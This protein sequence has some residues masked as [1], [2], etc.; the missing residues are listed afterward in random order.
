[1][2]KRIKY[3]SKKI[4]IL[5]NGCW[6]WTARRFSNGYG[7]FWDGARNRLAHRWS[8][9]H[10]VGS[11]PDDLCLDHLC[12]NRACVNPEHLEPVTLGEHLR[13]GDTITAR[14]AAQTHCIHGHALSGNNLIRRRNGTR[15][16]RECQ[17][18]NWRRTWAIRKQKE[19]ESCQ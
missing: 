1:M 19:L 11:I 13:R 4:S 9:E 7:Q 15:H 2:P 12:R 14:R 17:N 3:F 16:C 8:Y 18:I 6:E 10:H 5:E